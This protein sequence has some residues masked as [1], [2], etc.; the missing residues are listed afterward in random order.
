MM[1]HPSYTEMIEAV[2]A[3]Q[4][5]GTT[6]VVN[7]RYSIV[8]ATSHR[9]RQIVDGDEPLVE[10]AEGR[11]ALSVAVEEVFEG[12]V[13]ILQNEGEPADGI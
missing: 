7:S 9:A 11:K 8:M 6:P 3:D 13:K 5:D 1:M 2:N 10:G 12:K 4:E